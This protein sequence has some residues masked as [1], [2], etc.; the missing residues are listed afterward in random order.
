MNEKKYNSY[1]DYFRDFFKSKT[2]EECV[3][4]G[5]ALLSDF[6]RWFLFWFKVIYEK[7]FIVQEQYHG[8]LFETYNKILHCDDD[9]IYTVINLCPRSSKTELIRFSMCFFCVFIVIILLL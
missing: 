9:Y 6:R 2:D 8:D 5:E 4:F 7:E 3:V 1:R